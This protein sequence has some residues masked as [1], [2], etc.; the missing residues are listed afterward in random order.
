MNYQNMKRQELIRLLKLK[1]NPISVRN[2]ETAWDYLVPYS[3]KKQEYFIVLL[4]DGGCQIINLQ[5]V[6]IGIINRTL[7][8]PREVF[9][10]ALEQR[11]TSIII[12]HNH[13]SGDLSPSNEDLD[14]TKRMVQ[15]GR[16]LG[17]KVQDHIIFSSKGFFSFNA[18]NLLE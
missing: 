11:S 8:H 10:P 14:L 3:N 13:P 1:E 17:I 7:V 4:L 2:P 15:A 6:T 12:A 9:A 16:I 18:H 5:V